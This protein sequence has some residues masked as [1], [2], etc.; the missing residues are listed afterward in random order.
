VGSLAMDHPQLPVALDLPTHNY[1]PL[2]SSRPKWSACFFVTSATR[3]SPSGTHCRTKQ[4]PMHLSHPHRS[5]LYC[6]TG[7]SIPGLFR[8]RAAGTWRAAAVGLVS[9][10]YY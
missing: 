2:G 6:S 8:Y 3:V 10:M 7:L 5:F 9:G 4:W 1:L